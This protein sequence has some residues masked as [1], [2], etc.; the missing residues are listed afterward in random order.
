[1]LSDH[2][3]PPLPGFSCDPGYLL[4]KDFCYHFDTEH[5]FHWQE[6]ES[7]CASQ[8]G[9]LASLHDQAELSF[10]TG[11]ETLPEPL[12]ENQKTIEGTHR[13]H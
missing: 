12:G 5:T 10:L 4:Y 3:P 1:M 2:L 7:Y 11:Q 6:A 13:T 9:H 8:S